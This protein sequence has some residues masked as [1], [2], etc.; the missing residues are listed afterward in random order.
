[1]S[2]SLWLIRH[3]E[4]Q[5]EARGRCCG[6]LDVTLSPEGLRQAQRVADKLREEAFAAIYASPRQRC[7]DAAKILARGRTGAPK[8]LD[9]LR[10]IDF[11]EFEG[12]SYDEIA[13]SHPE[14]YRQWME[15]PTEVQFPGGESFH[16]MRERVVETAEML[17]RRHDGEAIALVTHGGVIRILIADALSIPAAN[18][19]RIAQWYSATNLIRYQEGVPSVELVNS[20]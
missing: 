6:T 9:A 20:M 3:P 2:T 16:Q 19:F 7:Q 12:R 18:I 10:E 15:H 4:P 5:E 8:T 1:M 17:R 13:A 11:G 14:L